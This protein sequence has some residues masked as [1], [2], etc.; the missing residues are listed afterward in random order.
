MTFIRESNDQY[1][2]VMYGKI[3]EVRNSCMWFTLVIDT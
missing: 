1:Q 2:T 3:N